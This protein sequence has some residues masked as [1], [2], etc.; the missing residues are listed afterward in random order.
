MAPVSAALAFRPNE[1]IAFRS[2]GR[3]RPVVQ[4]P[5]RRPLQ[6]RVVGCVGKAR[7]VSEGQLSSTSVI[8]VLNQFFQDRETALVTLAKTGR[9]QVNVVGCG[10]GQELLLRRSCRLV[11]SFVTDDHRRCVV[12]RRR[13]AGG[14]EDGRERP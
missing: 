1:R 3:K 10:F 4:N 11:G 9:D 6:Q 14:M 12:S 2:S 8:G 5:E 13:K 7:V